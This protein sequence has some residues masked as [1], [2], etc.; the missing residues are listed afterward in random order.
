MMQGV[1]GYLIMGRLGRRFMMERFNEINLTAADDLI[2]EDSIPGEIGMRRA[3]FLLIATLLVW[4]GSMLL[5]L[6]LANISGNQGQVALVGL[7]LVAIGGGCLWVDFF[8]VTSWFAS[9]V[10]QMLDD[11]NPVDVV[12]ERAKTHR[13]KLH[14]DAM[15]QE[16]SQDNPDGIQR[17]APFQWT[18]PFLQTV[19]TTMW[20]VLKRR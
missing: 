5:A 4:C 3:V 19:V 12:V 7:V 18:R 9:G 10:G 13:S 17:A 15:D 16:N 2:A 1:T 14:L 11:L 20:P 8:E 6:D